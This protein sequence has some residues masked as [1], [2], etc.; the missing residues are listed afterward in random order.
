LN[1][2]FAAI[3]SKTNVGPAMDV[4]RHHMQHDYTK[5]LEQSA[6]SNMVASLKRQK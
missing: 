5:R 6:A 3:A 2:A 4:I 1:E